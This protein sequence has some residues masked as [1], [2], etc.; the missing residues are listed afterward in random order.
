MFSYLLRNPTI[1]A[2]I[3]YVHLSAH[4]SQIYNI[5]RD[6]AQDPSVCHFSKNLGHMHMEA[7]QQILI[8]N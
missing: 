6:H 7:I 4:L 3:H 2:I 1:G 5:F 8:T